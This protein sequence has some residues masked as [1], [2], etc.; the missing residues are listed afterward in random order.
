MA[1]QLKASCVL[2][3]AAPPTLELIAVSLCVSDG[4]GT[5]RPLITGANLQIHRGEIVGLVGPS[6]AGKTTLARAILD[7]L[8]PGVTRTGDIRVTARPQSRTRCPLAYIDQD[9]GATLNPVRRV[10][11]QIVEVVRANRGCD[12]ATARTRAR[13]LFDR[14]SLSDALLE[15]YP[16]QLSGGQ[17]QRVAIARAIACDPAVVIADEP[18]SA[19][20]VVTQLEVIDAL[21]AWRREKGFAV[22]LISH[23]AP[24]LQ[25]LCERI[26]RVSDGR[27]LAGHHAAAETERCA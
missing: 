10:G 17:Q 2:P 23:E 13:H 9:P 4:R 1:P 12:T 24:L 22:L 7:I 26:V 20:D 19:L 6:G 15:A 18:G 11:G 14:L 25:H 3:V 8:P 5:S 27:L 16:H 21:L